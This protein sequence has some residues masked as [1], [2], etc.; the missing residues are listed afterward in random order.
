MFV[1]VF[2]DSVRAPDNFRQMKQYQIGETEEGHQNFL[3]TS[4]NISN[5]MPCNFTRLTVLVQL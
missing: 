2:R 1:I 4:S 5:I 3:A